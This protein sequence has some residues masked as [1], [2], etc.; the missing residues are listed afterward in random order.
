MTSPNAYDPPVAL[1]GENKGL[2]Q[3]V[4]AR[5]WASRTSLFSRRSTPRDFDNQSAQVQSAWRRTSEDV[6]QMLLVELA[7]Q[8]PAGPP[9]IRDTDWTYSW[10]ADIDSWEI[11]DDGG[12]AV[13]LITY[14][15]DLGMIAAAPRM[16]AAIRLLQAQL[17][18]SPV[19]EHPAIQDLIAS[20]PTPPT[21]PAK[22]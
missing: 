8:G 9:R 2:V 6:L 11:V 19:L 16:A 13:A 10:N 1:E 15:Q 5:L 4:A 12:G 21:K 14:H 18:G 3:A 20:L 22:D 7:F 17:Q